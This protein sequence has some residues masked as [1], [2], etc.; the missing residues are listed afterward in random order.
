MEPLTVA[1]AFRIAKA[2]GVDKMI[3]KVFG[4]DKAESMANK[5]LDV[6]QELTGERDIASIEKAI[7]ADPSLALQLTTQINNIAADYDKA[8]L[9]DIADARDMQVAALQQEDVFVRRFIYVFAMVIMLVS[10]VFIFG[11]TFVE[12]PEANQRVVDT[13]MG[14]MTG[15]M[16][17]TVL[18]F[19]F[20]AA[21]RPPTAVPHK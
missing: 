9:A 7:A 15:T 2:L 14:W 1:A 12:I 4:S 11:V 19:F 8:V 10:V 17:S 20:G 21:H 6:A 18:Y 5:V 13:I 16:M 3:G